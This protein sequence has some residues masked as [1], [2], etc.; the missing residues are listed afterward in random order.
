MH[1]KYDRRCIA[2]RETKQQSELLR[3]AKIDDKLYLDK[4]NKLDGRGAYMCKSGDCIR[5]V[6]KKRLLNKVF[7]MNVGNEIY[8]IL[9]EYEQNH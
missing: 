1:I 7:K 8:D 3:V 6:I 9:G 2:C 4:D 5:V